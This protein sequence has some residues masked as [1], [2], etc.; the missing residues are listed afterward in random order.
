MDG[1]I[2]LLVLYGVFKSVKKR[3]GAAKAKKKRIVSAFD[4]KKERIADQMKARTEEAIRR[5]A[6][7]QQTVMQEAAVPASTIGE[8]QSHS[9][10]DVDRHDTPQ[11]EYMG[12]MIVDS[13]EGECVCDPSISHGGPVRKER[14]GVYADEIGGEPLLDFS[15]ERLYQGV[16]MSEILA[17]PCERARRWR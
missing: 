13:D 17:R 4:E 16:V 6:E 9:T 5:Q 3:S 8:G 2:L 14:Q 12:S 7:S 1:L 10:I 15:A 11:P